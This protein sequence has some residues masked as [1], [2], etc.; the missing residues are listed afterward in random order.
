[1]ILGVIGHRN[2]DNCIC[3]G[4]QKK[5]DRQQQREYPIEVT[6][7]ESYGY[8][9]RCEYCKDIIEVWLTTHGIIYEM[10]GARNTMK[11]YKE[12]EE[13]RAEMRAMIMNI[14]KTYDPFSQNPEWNISNMWKK[15]CRE[16][17]S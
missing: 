11:R 7:T 4:C 17:V 14:V 1:M 9:L 10:W 12:N 2:E 16:R 6:N 15:Y 3:C 8:Y 13:K 5:L